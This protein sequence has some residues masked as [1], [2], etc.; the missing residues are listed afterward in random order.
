MISDRN[1]LT[2]LA[3]LAI[4]QVIGWGT[5]SLPAVLGR[6]MAVDL[7]L[8]LSA[9]FAGNSVL[10]V[11]IGLC[12]PLLARSFARHGGRRVMMVGTLVAAA[13]FTMLSAARGP[14]SYYIAWLGL[15]VAGSATLSTA[16][17][18][19]LNEVAGPGARR[20]IGALMLVTGLSSSI[21]WP[22][23][24]VMA[25]QL[26]WR[27]TCLVYAALLLLVSLPLLAALLPKR[28]NEQPTLAS[29]A[30]SAMA[31]PEPS[32]GTFYLL[33]AA[34][35]LNA[36]VT[37]GLSAVLIELLKVEG[38]TALEAI[39]FGSMLGVIQISARALD[40]LGGGRWDAITTALAAGLALP[41]AM[42]LLMVWGGSAGAVAVF[43]V[44]YGLGSG[45][46]AVARATM[47]LVFYDGAAFA[48][49]SAQIALPLNLLSATAA[50]VMAALLTSFGSNT[51]LSLTLICS[52]AALLMLL[53]LRL[54]RPAVAASA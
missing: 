13:G 47:P 35:A 45:A 5:L 51:L 53:L 8:S 29:D 31:R 32:Q 27:G 21:F 38:L 41:L 6:D 49:A 44:V 28:R 43:I 39:G 1:I 10:Y 19:V 40:L 54:L 11:A 30:G 23:S 37:M 52:S 4:T 7:G 46:L 12:S 25:A 22:V 9:V 15:G 48:K 36:F 17:Y 42:L 26:G 18:V 24:A 33:T 14:I 2:A 50:P 34:I 20:A 16:A 3:V